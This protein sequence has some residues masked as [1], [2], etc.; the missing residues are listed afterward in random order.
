MLSVQQKTSLMSNTLSRVSCTEEIKR[1]RISTAS[2]SSLGILIGEDG[3]TLLFQ[4]ML[5][6]LFCSHLHFQCT[7]RQLRSTRPSRHLRTGVES[8]ISPSFLLSGSINGTHSFRQ[9]FPGQP[10]TFVG[11]LFQVGGYGHPSHACLSR[12]PV[13]VSLTRLSLVRSV[14]EDQIFWRQFEERFA[15]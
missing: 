10:A 3:V 1:A 13:T 14:L 8:R 9:P 6:S 11:G 2:S 7:G 15:S 4:V 5:R 12:V